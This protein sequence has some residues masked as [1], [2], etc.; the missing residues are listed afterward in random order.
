MLYFFFCRQEPLDPNLRQLSPIQI[1]YIFFL[2]SI[3]NLSSHSHPGLSSAF[4]CPSSAEVLFPCLIF[5]VRETWHTCHTLLDFIV[6]I[7]DEEYNLWI[8]SWYNF[9][10]PVASV[11][12][13][14]SLLVF[15]I[16]QKNSLIDHTHACGET[17]TRDYSIGAVQDRR[18]LR[19]RVHE[20]CNR[21]IGFL[22]HVL[23][24]AFK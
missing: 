11:F 5:P 14:Y 16:A 4:P 12:G 15:S 2:R 3:L 9:H 22:G 20:Y 6:L 24:C 17:W 23:W 8:S 7:I 19:L 10:H 13:P 21:E 1:I 18:L